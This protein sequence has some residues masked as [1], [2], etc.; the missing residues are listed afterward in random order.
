MHLTELVTE[1]YKLLFISKRRSSIAWAKGVHLSVIWK[2]YFAAKQRSF[3][4]LRLY[5]C[6]CL[7]TLVDLTG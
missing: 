7:C 2:L 1:H 5:M 6:N 3:C 4:I